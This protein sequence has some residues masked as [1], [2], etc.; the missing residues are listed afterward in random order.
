MALADKLNELTAKA[1]QTAAEH[2]DDLHRVTDQAKNLANKQTRGKY[3]NQINK[4]A[5]KVDAL[6]DK[7]PD[8]PRDPP[9]EGGPGSSPSPE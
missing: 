2:K 3:H 8:Q 7:L 4:A 5:A 9:A 6:V 1:K